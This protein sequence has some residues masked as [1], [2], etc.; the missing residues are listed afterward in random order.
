MR[1]LYFLGISCFLM[2]TGLQAAETHVVGDLLSCRKHHRHHCREHRHHDRCQPSCH[3]RCSDPSENMHSVSYISAYS[4]N[5]AIQVINNNDVPTPIHFINVLSGPEGITPIPPL[6]IADS[7]AIQHP[8]VYLIGWTLTADTTTAT[9]GLVRV[10]LRDLTTGLDIPPSPNTVF[11]Q[12]DI[13]SA[14]GQ[15][16]VTFQE[17]GHLIQLLVTVDSSVGSIDAII[18]TPTLFITQIASSPSLL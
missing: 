9:A 17:P 13:E 6:P 8:G 12:G 7:F 10:I 2:L 14:S 5:T 15:T 1:C 4:P 3:D 11:S 16:I 18:A